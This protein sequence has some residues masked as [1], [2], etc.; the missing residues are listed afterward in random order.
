MC[1]ILRE[2]PQKRWQFILCKERLF[3]VENT[4]LKGRWGW[5]WVEYVS[6]SILWS[7]Q[8]ISTAGPWRDVASSLNQD[9]QT[10]IQSKS[11]IA[12]KG[13]RKTV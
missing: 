2:L 3:S 11:K 6:C 5:R 4:V 8:Q 9:S 7:P 1:F 12:N 13:I 10:R